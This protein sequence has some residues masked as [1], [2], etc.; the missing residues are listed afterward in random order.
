MVTVC[1]LLKKYCDTLNVSQLSHC[2]KLCGQLGF[3]GSVMNSDIANEMSQGDTNKDKCLKFLAKKNDRVKYR[4][5]FQSWWWINYVIGK[6]K[7]VCHYILIELKMNSSQPLLHVSNPGRD[8]NAQSISFSVSFSIYT[9]PSLCFKSSDS[10][11]F[12]L[13]FI[14]QHFSHCSPWKGKFKVPSSTQSKTNLVWFLQCFFNLE[15][16]TLKCLVSRE[17]LHSLC[18]GT[19]L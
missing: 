18:L 11:C 14:S 15:L 12:L 9:I 6:W 10:P 5:S 2:G 3:S 4:V 8:N 17:R 19:P 16:E 13:W 7:A 1:N